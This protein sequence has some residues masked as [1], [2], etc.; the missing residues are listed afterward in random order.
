MSS[1][2]AY[3]KVS[4]LAR[5]AT[6]LGAAPLLAPVIKLF[7][8]DFTPTPTSVIGDFTIA[9]FSGY[10]DVTGAF[11]APGID[12][13]GNAVA[14]HPCVWS[15]DGVTPGAAYGL[16]IVDSA[17]NLVAGARFDDAP[18]NF[19]NAGDQLVCTLLFGMQLGNVTVSLGP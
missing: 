11:G 9:S 5:L 13:S 16:Y 19:V 12:P 7:Q 14:P 4:A 3:S 6:M 1:P 8:N 15:T 10:A 2:L 18:Y 17:G